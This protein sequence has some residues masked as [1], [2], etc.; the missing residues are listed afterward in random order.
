M[1]RQLISNTSSNV[2]ANVDDTRVKSI[3]DQNTKEERFVLSE[4][5]MEYLAQDTRLAQVLFVIAEEAAN[6]PD[7]SCFRVERVIKKLPG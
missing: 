6:N 3:I 5:A 2:I 4:E 7:E 1:F